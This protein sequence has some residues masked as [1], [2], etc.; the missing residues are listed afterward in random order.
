MERLRGV[1]SQD[2]L[3]PKMEEWL[4]LRRA[5]E[6]RITDP[7]LR[8]LLHE[9]VEVDLELCKE[10]IQAAYERGLTAGENA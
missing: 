8:T 7:E 2:P 3:S 5:L 9:F 1:F 4:R 10:E 6:D